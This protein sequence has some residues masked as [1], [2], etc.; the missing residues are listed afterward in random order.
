MPTLARMLE[1]FLERVVHDLQPQ[2]RVLQVLVLS[3]LVDGLDALAKLLH[4]AH[5][6]L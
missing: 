2:V 6:L 1:H 3:T 5:K 4:V